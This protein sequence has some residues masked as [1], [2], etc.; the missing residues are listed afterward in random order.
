MKD[1][2]IN[3]EKNEQDHKKHEM[4]ILGSD[5]FSTCFFFKP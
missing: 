5:Q 3:I 4:S 2:R 1:I